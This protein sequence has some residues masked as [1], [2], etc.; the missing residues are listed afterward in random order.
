MP[1]PEQSPRAFTRANIEALRPGQNGCYGL[2]RPGEWIYVGKGHIRQRLL[3]HFN[4]DNTCITAKQPTSWVDV[5]TENYDEL[6]SKLIR[7]LSP[8][9]NKRVG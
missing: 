3:D 8:T 1:F 9:C 4:G 2:F 7:E 6:E 5:V